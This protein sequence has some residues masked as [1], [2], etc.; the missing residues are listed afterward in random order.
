MVLTG[1]LRRDVDRRSPHGN[2]FLSALSHQPSASFSELAHAVGHT[3]VRVSEVVDWIARA[4][5]SG[6]I[7]ADPPAADSAPGPR[8]VRLTDRGRAILEVPR[9]AGE[10]RSG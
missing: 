4:E 5:S 8:R 2:H 1:P 6:L 3:R 7:E 9:R 10:R